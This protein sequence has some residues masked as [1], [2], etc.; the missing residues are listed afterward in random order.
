MT[1]Y[2]S[3]YT[4]GDLVAALR[5]DLLLDATTDI[6]P[7]SILASLVDQNGKSAFLQLLTAQKLQLAFGASTLAWTTGSAASGIVT[8]SHGLGRQPPLRGGWVEWLGG[9]PINSP[10]VFQ[11]LNGSV[12]TTQFQAQGRMAA[13]APSNFTSTFV[14]FVIG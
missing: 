10:Q 9:D 5:K 4:Y 3:H 2:L 12:T 13:A 11:I 8:V 6:L 14:W 1:T 7:G